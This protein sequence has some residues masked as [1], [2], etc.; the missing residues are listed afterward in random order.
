MCFLK[1][2]DIWILLSDLL[3]QPVSFGYRDE[4]I[5]VESHY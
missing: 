1:T 2:K 5:A 3:S 4:S